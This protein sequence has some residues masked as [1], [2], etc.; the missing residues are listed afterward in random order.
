MA[1]MIGI[2]LGATAALA[3]IELEESDPLWTPI[4]TALDQLRNTL[5]SQSSQHIVHMTNE[6]YDLGKRIF[7]LLKQTKGMA[8]YLRYRERAIQEWYRMLMWYQ[9]MADDIAIAVRNLP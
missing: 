8:S 7:N 9:K 2:R 5:M 3:R 6:V 1:D 4:K